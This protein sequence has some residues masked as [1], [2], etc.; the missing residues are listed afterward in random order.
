M[1]SINVNVA[2]ENLIEQ[3]IKSLVSKDVDPDPM[4]LSDAI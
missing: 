1:E 3:K 4:F 2:S